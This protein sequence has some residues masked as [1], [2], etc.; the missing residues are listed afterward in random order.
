MDR[1]TADAA[2]SEPRMG[3]VL[4]VRAAGWIDMQGH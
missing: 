2:I 3:T 1:A 4:G